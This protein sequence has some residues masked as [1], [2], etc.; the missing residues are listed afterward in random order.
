MGAIIYFEKSREDAEQVTYRYGTEAQGFVHALVIDKTAQRPKDV[1]RERAS[2]SVQIAYGGILKAFRN[3][4]E[5]P[6]SGAG[7]G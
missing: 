4:G 3:K 6:D 2:A 1:D 7:Y 5:W